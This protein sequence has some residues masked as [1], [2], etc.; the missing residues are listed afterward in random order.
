MVVPDS[1]GQPLPEP[2]S[3]VPPELRL[4]MVPLSEWERVAWPQPVRVPVPLVWRGWQV[5]WVPV[6]VWPGLV[7]VRERVWLVPEVWPWGVE[8]EPWRVPVQ[9]VWGWDG[10]EERWQ[11]PGVPVPVERPVGLSAVLREG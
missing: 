7:S 1:P 8:P 5:A 11:E 10:G 4:L 6:L 3:V 2:S 9:V